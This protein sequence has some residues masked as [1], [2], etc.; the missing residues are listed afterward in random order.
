MG[1]GFSLNFSCWVL[2]LSHY[3]LAVP[4]VGKSPLVL[5]EVARGILP[6]AWNLTDNSF[7]QHSHHIGYKVDNHSFIMVG[8]R[9]CRL[10]LGMSPHGFLLLFSWKSAFWHLK[11]QSSL[12]LPSFLS[13]PRLRLRP[14]NPCWNSLSSGHNRV[15]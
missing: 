14:K 12:T 13:F 8:K 3:Y 1:I 10:S 6:Q 4:L 15:P 7:A 9:D 2:S 11:L 5:V